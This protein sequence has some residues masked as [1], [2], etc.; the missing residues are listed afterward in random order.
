[1]RGYEHLFYDGLPR[2]RFPSVR[3]IFV[4]PPTTLFNRN[5]VGESMQVDERDF[6]FARLPTMTPLFRANVVPG[7]AHRPAAFI[8]SR[9]AGVQSVQ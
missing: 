2:G 8:A 6:H 7:Y 4:P 1:L 9:C 3:E 5:N